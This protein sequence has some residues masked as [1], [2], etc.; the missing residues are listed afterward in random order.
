MIG[1]PPW[2]RFELLRR[3]IRALELRKDSRPQQHTQL[4]GCL[5]QPGQAPWI[6]LELSSLPGSELPTIRGYRSTEGPLVIVLATDVV[7]SKPE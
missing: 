5:V 3:E 1:S 4:T 2:T 7:T 6:H